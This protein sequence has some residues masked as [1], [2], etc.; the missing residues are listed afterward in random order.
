M[1]RKSAFNVLQ[2]RRLVAASENSPH[3][4]VAVTT[5]LVDSL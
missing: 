5:V 1:F 2:R 3:L 4:S